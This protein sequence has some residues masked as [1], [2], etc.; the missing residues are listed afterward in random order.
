MATRYPLKTKKGEPARKV[1]I[2]S[3]LTEHEEELVKRFAP[4][5]EV[6]VGQYLR[7]AFRKGLDAALRSDR[8]AEKEGLLEDGETEDG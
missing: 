1:R 4:I 6:S 3:Y 5:Y 7:A 2:D 8:D